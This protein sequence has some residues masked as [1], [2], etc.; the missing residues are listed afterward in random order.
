MNKIADTGKL[1]E[2]VLSFSQLNYIRFNAPV[3]NGLD[4]CR[5]V[6]LISP[7]L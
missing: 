3:W 2:L 1:I 4:I 6:K 5:N 7:Y